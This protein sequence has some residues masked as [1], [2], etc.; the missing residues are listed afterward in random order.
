MNWTTVISWLLSIIILPVGYVRLSMWWTEREVNKIKE[1]IKDLEGEKI[2]LLNLMIE[3]YD[4][5]FK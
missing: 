2:Q 1:E 5:K 3:E 4:R